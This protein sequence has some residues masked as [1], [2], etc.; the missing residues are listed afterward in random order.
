MKQLFN[1]IRIAYLEDMIEGWSAGEESAKKAAAE[2]RKLIANKTPGFRVPVTFDF[3]VPL[4]N[5]YKTGI[6]LRSISKCSYG[7]DSD[8]INGH[9]DLDEREKQHFRWLVEGQWPRSATTTGLD[10]MS[11]N[12]D[13]K[14]LGKIPADQVPVKLEEWLTRIGFENINFNGIDIEEKSEFQADKQVFE[15]TADW[16]TR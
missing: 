12:R 8:K 14:D 10:W 16:V 13:F 15:F 2:L 9:S 6:N 1:N 7:I 11:M 5:V 4:H 3:C